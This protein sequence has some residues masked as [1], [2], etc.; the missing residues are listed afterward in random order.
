MLICDWFSI[1][2]VMC[3]DIYVYD[4]VYVIVL[5]FL[6]VCNEVDYCDCTTSDCV[7]CGDECNRTLF[8]ISFAMIV[9]K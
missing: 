6:R 1:V 2:V 3:N 4:G 5:S 9:F 8:N 7:R